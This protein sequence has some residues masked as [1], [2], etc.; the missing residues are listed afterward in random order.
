MKVIN[1]KILLK[2]YIFHLITVLNFVISIE[3]QNIIIFKDVEALFDLLFINEKHFYKNFNNKLK[4][5]L[6]RFR[7][8]KSL[9]IL[10]HD[11]I[12]YN[13]I[14]KIFL[15]LKKLINI[16][17]YLKLSLDDLFTKNLFLYLPY[18]FEIKLIFK[19]SKL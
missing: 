19:N 2:D 1:T 14:Y 15:D 3:E 13:K 18:N 12:L 9:L 11:I 7:K 10:K 4:Y 8:L 5:F 16:N 17:D 6:A